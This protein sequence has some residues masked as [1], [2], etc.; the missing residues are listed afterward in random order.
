M[1]GEMNMAIPRE[2]LTNYLPDDRYV[3]IAYPAEDDLGMHIGMYERVEEIKKSRMT[4]FFRVMEIRGHDNNLVLN[5]KL[6]KNGRILTPNLFGI[7]DGYQCRKG[8]DI[9]DNE[10]RKND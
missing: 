10:R 9:K 8:K 6:G 4:F 5:V 2:L 3:L 1:Q 7:V